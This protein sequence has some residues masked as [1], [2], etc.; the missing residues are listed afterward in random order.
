MQQ[1]GQITRRMS[2]WVMLCLALTVAGCSL[3]DQT[4]VYRYRLTVEVDTPDGVKTGSSVIEVD[5]EVAG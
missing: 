4:P 2:G 5:T 1:F 3:T